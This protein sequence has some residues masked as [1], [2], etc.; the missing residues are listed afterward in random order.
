MAGK[1][2]PPCRE[3]P[4]PPPR[5]PADLPPRGGRSVGA[6]G[7]PLRRSLGLG[8][9]PVLPRSA[10]RAPLRGALPGALLSRDAPLLPA[11]PVPFPGGLRPAGAARPPPGDGPRG[12]GVARR[13]RGVLPPGGRLR[14]AEGPAGRP[15]AFSGSGTGTLAR[16][17]AGPSGG[18]TLLGPS[19]PA[20]MPHQV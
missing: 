18:E 8:S 19:A 3:A 14:H 20:P 11:G 1:A 17:R 5:L 7:G 6:G 4:P 9:S 2:P 13:L 12:G 16:V 10:R 15:R